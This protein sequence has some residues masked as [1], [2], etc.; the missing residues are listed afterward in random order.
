MINLVPNKNFNPYV[1]PYVHFLDLSIEKQNELIKKD[2]DFSKLICNCEKVTLGEIKDVLNRH[3]KPSTLKGVKKRTRAGFGKCQS[4]FC[5]S[6][7]IDILST[8]YQVDKTKILYDKI[9]SN[10]LFYKTKVGENND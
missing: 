2:K 9:N 1:R 3:V 10:I 6:N 5:Q 8:F 7:I 4:G